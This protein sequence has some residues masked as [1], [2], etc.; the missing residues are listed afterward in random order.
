[1]A[2]PPQ[3]AATVVK[4]LPAARR[5]RGPPDGPLSG[6]LL[7]M[8]SLFRYRPTKDYPA[9][10]RNQEQIRMIA[11]A[12]GK[13]MA[14]APPIARVNAESRFA[15]GRRL[16]TDMLRSPPIGKSKSRHPD[17][18]VTAFWLAHTVQKP[19]GQGVPQD[20]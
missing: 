5:V 7:A 1:M 18:A 20:G 11:T 2:D 9:R 6:Y 15:A 19:Q 12:I 14:N 3:S 13:P 10:T 17:E 8:K 16:S 4:V